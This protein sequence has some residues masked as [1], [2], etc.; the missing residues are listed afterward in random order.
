MAIGGTVALA[1]V[2]IIF[3]HR[4]APYFNAGTDFDIGFQF[5]IA[6]QAPLTLDRARVA[7]AV[8]SSSGN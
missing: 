2:A 6:L 7:A 1:V 4:H 8:S 5:E 3:G